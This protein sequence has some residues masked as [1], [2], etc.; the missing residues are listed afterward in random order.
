ME[1][2]AADT[3]YRADVPAMCWCNEFHLQ[4]ECRMLFSVIY[5]ADVP[6]DVDVLDFAPPSLDLWDETEDD[7]QYDYGGSLGVLGFG[8]SPAISSSSDDPEAIQNAYVTPLP[9]VKRESCGEEDW[10][11]VRS[12]ALSVYG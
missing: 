4:Q 9:E 3:E 1:F 11:R 5:S 6:G 10:D 7:D 12:A 2:V 8:W